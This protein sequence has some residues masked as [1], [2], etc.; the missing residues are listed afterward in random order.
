MKIIFPLISPISFFANGR[1]VHDSFDAFMEL[2]ARGGKESNPN[3]WL[4]A[5]VPIAS[6][7]KKNKIVSQ[8]QAAAWDTA[9]AWSVLLTIEIT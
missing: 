6:T 5:S 1:V 8:M 7:D 9:D 3:R 4:H 2:K